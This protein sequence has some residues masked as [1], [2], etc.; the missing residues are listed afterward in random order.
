MDRIESE[1]FWLFCPHFGDEFVWREALQ[2][3]ETPAVIVSADE[4]REVALELRV[5]VVV[6]ALDGGFL[7]RA[8]HTFDLTIGP[9]MPDLGQLVLNAVLATAHVKHMGRVP[10]RWAIGV[11]TAAATRTKRRGRAEELIAAHK[12]Q[13]RRSIGVE[14]GSF[15]AGGGCDAML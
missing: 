2:G 8:V 15:G 9:R 13:M 7:D 4:V 5:A 1:S 12:T 10:G 11:V 6:I 14:S 3:Y